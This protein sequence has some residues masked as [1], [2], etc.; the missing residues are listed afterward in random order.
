M[1]RGE[2]IGQLYILETYPKMLGLGKDSPHL[3]YWNMYHV[4]VCQFIP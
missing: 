4:G 3:I 1:E 2:S